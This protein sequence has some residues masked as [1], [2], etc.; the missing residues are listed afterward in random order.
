MNILK[1]LLKQKLT[2]VALVMVCTILFLAA[3]APIVAPYDPNYVDLEKK[4]SPPTVS[5]WLGTDH[6]GRDILSRLI[7]GARV[8]VGSVASIIVCILVLGFIV[9]S[10]AGYTG[11]IVDS[12]LMRLCDVFLTFPTFILAMFLVGVLGTG[13]TNVVIA[14]VMTHWAWYARLIRG[15]VLSMKN[16]DYILAARVAGTPKIK[17]IIRHIVP[18]VFAQLIILATLDIGHM[19]LHVSG[20]SFL[21]LGITPPTPE[22][23]VMINDARQFIWSTPW[24]IVYPGLMIFITVMSFNLLGDALRDALDPTTGEK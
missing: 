14:I 3:A 10:I 21:G 13:L 18:P 20:L 9:G 11:G 1:R 6:L 8:S 7:F 22:W 24:L 16:R 17:I 15:F 19:M 2:A 23:G 5:H 12:I 4:L